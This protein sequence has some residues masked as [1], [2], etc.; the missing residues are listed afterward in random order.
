MPYQHTFVMSQALKGVDTNHKV[1]KLSLIPTD[2][3]ATL[4]GAHVRSCTSARLISAKG[5]LF[6]AATAHDKVAPFGTAAFV[7]SGNK[8][9]TVH[10][11]ANGGRFAFAGQ[12]MQFDFSSAIGV[13]NVIKGVKGPGESPALHLAVASSWDT[14]SIDVAF[15]SMRFVVEFDGVSDDVAFDGALPSATA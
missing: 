5:V 2:T 1:Y 13:D 3:S 6:M 11:L 4:Y 12:D 9:T 8:A 7:A 10:G 14:L 15:F